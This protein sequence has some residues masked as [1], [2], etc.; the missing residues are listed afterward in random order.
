MRGLEEVLATVSDVDVMDHDPVPEVPTVVAAVAPVPK[1]VVQKFANSSSVL[2]ADAPPYLP[3]PPGELF[4]MLPPS[5]GTLDGALASRVR[6]WGSLW[7]RGKDVH[8][9]VCASLGR[10]QR[11]LR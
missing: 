11:R 1:V 5:T 10:L 4:T 7:E 9:Q 8:G 2:H 6:F 3:G